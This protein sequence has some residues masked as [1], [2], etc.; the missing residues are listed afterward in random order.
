MKES[1]LY[2]VGF[3]VYAGITAILVEY[4]AKYLIGHILILVWFLTNYII[5]EI[6]GK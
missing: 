5:N 2:A 6:K 4:N 1:N 3:I